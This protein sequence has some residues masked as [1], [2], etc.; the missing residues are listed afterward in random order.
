MISSNHCHF[1]FHYTLGWTPR[2]NVQLS[3]LFS[4]TVTETSFLFRGTF[5]TVSAQGLM[6]SSQS[7]QVIKTVHTQCVNLFSAMAPQLQ[8]KCHHSMCIPY[9]E[10][11]LKVSV[12]I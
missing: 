10:F 12:P 1:S 3:D 8:H 9:N 4:F 6:P 7:W 5:L 11:C 2:Q